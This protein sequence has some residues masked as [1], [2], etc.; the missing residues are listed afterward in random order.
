M[1][2]VNEYGSVVLVFQEAKVDSNCG[3]N[4]NA[5]KNSKHKGK[6]LDETGLEVA[7]CRHRLGQKAINM[8]QGELF[9]Y[10]LFL[11]KEFIVPKK[12]EYCLADVMCKLWKFIGQRESNIQKSIK[13]ALSVMHVS[14]QAFACQVFLSIFELL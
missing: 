1:E 4:W 13:P 5:A 3:G 9:G 14:G 12:I 10:P 7:T 11:I 8:F 6:S 2:S